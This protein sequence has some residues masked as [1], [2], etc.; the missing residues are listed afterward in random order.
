MWQE[1]RKGSIMWQGIVRDK[2][3]SCAR[4]AQW[5]KVEHVQLQ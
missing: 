1:L 4:E 3:R 2:V 5:R